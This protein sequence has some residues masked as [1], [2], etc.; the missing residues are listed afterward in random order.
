MRPCYACNCCPRNMQKTLRRRHL[1]WTE[2][3]E[4]SYFQACARC[5]VQATVVDEPTYLALK[6]ALRLHKKKAGDEGL[7]LAQDFEP[8]CLRKGGR[9]DP[10][11]SLLDTGLFFGL[12]QFQST[13]WFGRQTGRP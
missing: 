11:P 13:F 2:N 4:Q 1:P 10:T 3:T 9:V 7:L 5:E 6:A 12:A 8:L